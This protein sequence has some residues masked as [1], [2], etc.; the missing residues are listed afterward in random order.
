MTRT[1]RLAALVARQ[2]GADAARVAARLTLDLSTR[3]L[4]RLGPSDADRREGHLADLVAM[5]DD[6]EPEPEPGV[7]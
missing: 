3:A 1:L 4:V 2:L 7:H 5:L 6:D